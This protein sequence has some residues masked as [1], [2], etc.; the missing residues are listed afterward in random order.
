M[1]FRIR[2]KWRSFLSS[3]FLMTLALATT[4]CGGSQENQEAKSA[5]WEYA[6]DEPDDGLEMEQEFGGMNEE[7]VNITVEKLYPE[8][9][10]CLMDAQRRMNFLGGEVAFL[11]KVNRAGKAEIAHAEHSTLGDFQSEQCMLDKLRASR[12]PKPVGGLIGLA[13]TSIAFDPPSD[14]RPP[15]PWT[16]EDVDETLKENQ[17]ELSACG[18]GGPFKVTAYV[19]TDGSVLSAGIAHSDDNAQSTA[20]CLVGAI[21]Q[22]EF[23]SPGSWPA[24]VTFPL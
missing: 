11:V 8:L 18:G 23:D 6:E 4:A 5:N 15:V 3:S 1:S 17:E 22:L 10:N 2:A 12:W 9:T 14:V 24:K 7:K 20:S 13:R 21:Q 19:A 16:V